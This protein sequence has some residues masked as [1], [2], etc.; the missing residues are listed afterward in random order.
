MRNEYYICGDEV[1][2]KLRSKMYGTSWTI[3]D[4]DVLDILLKLKVTW[5][6]R[7]SKYTDYVTC[8]RLYGK[9]GPRFHL[10]RI[11]L[12]LA[13]DSIL[14]PDHRNRNGLDNR[15]ENLRLVTRSQNNFNKRMQSNNKSGVNGV[16]LRK[17]TN[18]WQAV[19]KLNGKNIYLGNFPKMEDAIEARS[20]AEDAYLP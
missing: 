4:L 10:H 9:Y 8:N 6:V 7:P 3:V 18:V 20:K 5:I 11:V 17:N 16:F 12:G 13:K 15:K 19:I 14:E 2:I 1:L